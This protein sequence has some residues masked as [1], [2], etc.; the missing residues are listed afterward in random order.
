MAHR[1]NGSGKRRTRE[2]VIADLSINHVERQ[3][4][5]AGHTV[6]RRVHDYGIDLS[7]TTYDFDGI[8][9]PG[10]VLMQVKATDGIRTVRRGRAVVCRV[11]RVHL[12][13]WLAEPL[14]VI[15]I[16]YDAVQDRA[17]WLCIQ[18]EFTGTRRFSAASGPETATIRIPASQILDAAAAGVIREIRQSFLRRYEGNTHDPE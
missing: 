4:L 6:E 14:P 3:V 10:V 5:L 13:A 12:R 9:E 11:E 16:L 17:Y 1:L 8:P 2:H 15:L 7:L 18:R